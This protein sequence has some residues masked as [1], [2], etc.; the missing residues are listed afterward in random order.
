MVYLAGVLLERAWL[1]V[2]I[3]APG[4]DVG[5]WEVAE[6]KLIPRQ[7]FSNP[8]EGGTRLIRNSLC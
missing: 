2:A 4:D 5:K 6:R 7:G 1:L 8:C 3:V